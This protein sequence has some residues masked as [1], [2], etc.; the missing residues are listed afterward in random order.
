[1]TDGRAWKQLLRKPHRDAGDRRHKQVIEGFASVKARE[2]V[3]GAGELLSQ[4]TQNSRY[5]ERVAIPGR[6][7]TWFHF[8]SPATASTRT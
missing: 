7:P 3:A 8:T 4:E 1:M 5:V 6:N 2:L